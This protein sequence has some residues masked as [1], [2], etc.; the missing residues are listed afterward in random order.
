MTLSGTPAPPPPQAGAPVALCRTDAASPDDG[1]AQWRVVSVREVE[2]AIVEIAAVHHDPD[3][4]R[5]ID[6]ALPPAAA[7]RPALPGDPSRKL[8]LARGVTL[9]TAESEHFGRLRRE[10]HLAWQFDHDPRIAGWLVTASGPA[11]TRRKR[12]AAAGGAIPTDGISVGTTIFGLFESPSGWRFGNNFTFH[13]VGGRQDFSER[14]H[15][16]IFDR[17]MRPRAGIRIDYGEWRC[18]YDSDYVIQ[19][20]GGFFGT[21]VRIA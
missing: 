8:P 4:Y 13:P 17:Q 21:F 3:K 19:N 2:D 10:S 12:A 9:E 7:S 20:T 11:V 15:T 5:R 6:A 18:I 1:V 14:L 16:V